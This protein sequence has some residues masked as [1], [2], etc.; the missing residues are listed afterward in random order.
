MGGRVDGLSTSG[1]QRAEPAAGGIPGAPHSGRT[2]AKQPSCK[3]RAP[4]LPP[5][6]PTAPTHPLPLLLLLA[7]GCR[8][9]CKPCRRA[10]A[11]PRSL[12]CSLWRAHP[13][14]EH[15][16]ASVAHILQVALGIMKRVHAHLAMHRRCKRQ[17]ASWG[18]LAGAPRRPPAAG[19]QA[20]QHRTQRR[21]ACTHASQCSAVRRRSLAWGAHRLLSLAC[22]QPG[23]HRQQRRAV[24]FALRRRGAGRAAQRQWVGGSALA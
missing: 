5:A 6:P 15:D 2:P 10:A 1:T 4:L 11:P 3:P 14:S 13:H 24:V 16:V 7:S 20:V 17:G 22:R 21:A 12:Q 9:R 18:G 19:R 8:C 23:P